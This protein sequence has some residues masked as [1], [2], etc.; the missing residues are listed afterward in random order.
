MLRR[1]FALGAGN[2]GVAAIAVSFGKRSIDGDRIAAALDR[3]SSLMEADRDVAVDQK[4]ILRHARVAGDLIT[5]IPAM[6][7]LE[8]R[9]CSTPDGARQGFEGRD[10]PWNPG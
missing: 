10:G 5:E 1:G 9:P 7:P 4:S 8:P 2:Q 6:D 3:V